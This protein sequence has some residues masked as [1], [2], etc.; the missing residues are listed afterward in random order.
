M[1]QITA[2]GIVCLLSCWHN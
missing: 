1:E 2:S